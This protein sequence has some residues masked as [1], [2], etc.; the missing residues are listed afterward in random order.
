MIIAGE[1]MLRRKVS[2]LELYGVAS[3]VLVAVGVS[4]AW[5]SFA[6]PGGAPG[7]VNTSAATPGREDSAEQNLANSPSE[8]EALP[9]QPTPAPKPGNPTV[10]NPQQSVGAP[11]PNGQ[12]ANPKS[13]QAPSCTYT[14]AQLNYFNGQRTGFQSQI[15][16][17]VN[18]I[19]AIKLSYDM[20]ER[21]RDI[22]GFTYMVQ[23]RRDAL[24]RSL[25][26]DP[27]FAQTDPVA[28]NYWAVE[29]IPYFQDKLDHVSDWSWYPTSVTDRIN[30]VQSQIDTLQVQ[31][32]LVPT[33]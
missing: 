3:I 15:N 17:L 12:S 1:R 19:S 25:A 20:N 13:S 7:S 5:A 21:Q 31:Q 6:S 8:G 11:S 14:Q 27:N 28:Y 10:R 30:A 2:S 26:A 23:I 32:S 29:T 4:W 22:D 33:C 16:A 18:Q 24:E 9:L